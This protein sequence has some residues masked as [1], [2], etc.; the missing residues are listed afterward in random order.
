MKVQH[1]LVAPKLE[2]EDYDVWYS[3]DVDTPMKQCRRQQPIQIWDEKTTS[4]V[5]KNDKT[6]GIVYTDTVYVQVLSNKA[7]SF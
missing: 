6:M 4:Q 2:T 3:Y 1:K 7:T 5:E